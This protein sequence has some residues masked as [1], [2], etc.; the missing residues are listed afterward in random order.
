MKL[1]QVS[2]VGEK[3]P[4]A[5]RIT[6]LLPKVQLQSKIIKPAFTRSS[7]LFSVGV[8]FSSIQQSLPWENR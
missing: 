1:D 7:F 3:P 2:A 6:C 5:E 4:P 8:N